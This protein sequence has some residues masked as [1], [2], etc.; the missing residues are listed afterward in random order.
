MAPFME[1]EARD[2]EQALASACEELKIPQ[3]QIN[4]E[5]RSRGATGIFGLLGIRKARIRVHLPET[6]TASP[7]TPSSAGRGAVSNPH[8]I[9]PAVD[10]PPAGRG[11]VSIPPGIAPA[12]DRPP[13][14]RRAVSNPP[15]AGAD[16]VSA[17]RAADIAPVAPSTASDT[18]SPEYVAEA[19]AFLQRLAEA[20]C[21]DTHISVTSERKRIKFTLQ[22]ANNA[23]LVGKKGETLAALQ[24]LLERKLYRLNRKHARVVVDVDDYLRQ[25]RQ[26]L[27][28]QAL[29]LAAKVQET[30]KS[31]S[32]GNLS[33][34]ERRIVHLTLKQQPRVT[35]KSLGT[36]YLRKL[37]IFPR[38][39]QNIEND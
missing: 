3:D 7:D 39:A 22:S 15:D 32:M 36:G 17:A 5:V 20:I 10:S 21:P 2:V 26:K 19:S 18:P 33:P 27:K 29:E 31:L 38:H 9:A 23:F 12:A 37:V 8:D 24:Y 6:P 28:Q 34:R 11:A 30:R 35:T 16:H 4:Y 25:Q 1:F 14:G 13:A